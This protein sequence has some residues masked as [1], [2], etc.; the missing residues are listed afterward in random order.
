MANRVDIYKDNQPHKHYMQHLKRPLR[1]G[2]A[3]DPEKRNEFFLIHAQKIELARQKDIENVRELC[4][5]EMERLHNLDRVKW[6]DKI[7]KINEYMLDT[8]EEL[9]N[10]N[11]AE[12]YATNPKIIVI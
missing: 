2:E 8:L 9:E 4:I 5:A 11:P 1:K 3:P 7:K 12:F 6:A 10:M